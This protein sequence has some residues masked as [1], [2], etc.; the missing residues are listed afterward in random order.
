MLTNGRGGCQRLN[1]VSVNTPPLRKHKEDIPLLVNSFIDQV[2]QN[3]SIDILKIEASVFDILMDY[4]WPGNV[5]ELKNAIERAAILAEDNIIR[6]ENLPQN[7]IA[8]SDSFS[9]INGHHS[10]ENLSEHLAVYEKQIIINALKKNSFN[11]SRTANML[12]I[13]RKTLYNKI[14][15]HGISI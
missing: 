1:V 2:K 15:K 7:L 5:R 14:E 11:K 4:D 9:G 8:N 6:T 12:G 13:S 3:F 10:E